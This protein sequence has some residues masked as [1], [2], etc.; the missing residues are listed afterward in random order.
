MVERETQS[1]M[2]RGRREERER[3][4][5]FDL[6]GLFITLYYFIALYVKIKD[7]ILGKS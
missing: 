4:G 7:E 5:I 3:V 6:I 2:K 1:E